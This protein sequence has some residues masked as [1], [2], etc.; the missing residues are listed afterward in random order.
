MKK[1]LL[2]SL[3]T[4]FCTSFYAQEYTPI[5]AKKKIVT[6]TFYSDYIIEDKYR[7][8]ENV[9]SAETKE[10][11][12]FQD[13]MTKKYL[14]KTTNKTNALRAIEKYAYSEFENPIKMGNY[15]FNLAYYDVLSV[16]A[17]YYRTSLNLPAQKLVDPNFISTKEKI[18]LK[19]FDVSKD[20]KLLAYQ[21]NRNGT[22]WAEVKV[23]SLQTG[24]HEKDHLTGLKFSDLAWLN[25]GFFYSTF[26]QDSQFGL[27]GKQQV[28]YHK[29]ETEQKEDVLIFERKNNPDKTFSFITTS[30]ERFFILEEENER[31]GKTN[32]FYIDYQSDQKQIRP[33]LMRLSQDISILDSH[34]GK[35][36]AAVYQGSNNG[37][38]VEID[39]AK[40]FDWRAI[41]NAFPEALL[42]KTIPYMDRVVAVYQMNQRPVITVFGYDGAILHNMQLPVASSVG[43]FSGNYSDEELIF[44]F[45]SYTVPPVVYTFNINT[46]ARKLVEQTIVTFSVK[47]IVYEEMEYPSENGIK[48][49]MI[50]VYKEGLKLDG[51]NPAIL[52]AY[53]GF[54]VVSQPSFDPG[55]VHF[56]KKGGVFAFAN[57]RGGGDKGAEW[58]IGG[59][60]ANKQNSF[61]DFI[62]GAEFLVEKKYTNPEKLAITGASNGGLVVAVAAMQ[63]PELFKA[64]VPVVAPLDML[65]FE[66]FTIGQF[67]KDEYGT[68]KDSTSFAS[69]YS[70][71]PYHNIN[72]E[73]NYPSMLVMTSENDDRVPPFHS[74]KFVAHLQSR[75][76]Q[77]N[78][79]LLKTAKQAGHHGAATYASSIRELS[80]IYGF[81]MYQLQVK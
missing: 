40:P 8:L 53:G 70:Y 12:E 38:I 51:N 39:P 4:I 81:I 77:L 26:S 3:F 2:F 16:P 56:I 10:W 13:K 55:I 34:D 78:P 79:I 48:V 23:V 5:Y 73:I 30:D 80:D 36:I 22:D 61:D 21:F 14:A 43:N 32:I 64:V 18:V 60:G 41:A 66:E 42:I 74:S 68:V 35:L 19:D 47:D 25:D 62:A 65:R 20:S 15:Y 63:R 1:T 46:F 9:K 27:T 29:V 11:V 50:L 76:A 59:K 24:I 49:P 52:K 37:M 45:R 33:L 7:W 69:L 75:M 44:Y 57:I 31:T 72:N 28:W 71:S 54:G 67:H 17:L 58:A 6:D